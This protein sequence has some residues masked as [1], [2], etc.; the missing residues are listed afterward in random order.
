MSEDYGVDEAEDLDLM[1]LR[2]A[3]QQI[4]WAGITRPGGEVYLSGDLHPY[5]SFKAMKLAQFAKV[6]YVAVSAVRVLF[7]ADWL[8]AECLGDADRLRVIDNAAAFVR[9]Q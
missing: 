4:G 2:V 8:R 1:E 9:G 7:P 5:G 6:P 3:G